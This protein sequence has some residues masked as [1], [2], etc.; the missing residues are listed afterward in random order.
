MTEFCKNCNTPVDNK[1]CPACGQKTSVSRFTMK[2][3]FHDFVH[4]FFHVDHGLFYT[5]K[6]LAQNP[7]KMLRDYLRGHRIKYFNPF[8]FILLVGGLSAF[9]LP[10]VHWHSYFIDI[11]IIVKKSVDQD[12]WNSSLKHFSIR[13]LLGIPLYALVTKIFYYRK[14]Y[15]FSEHLIANTFIRAELSF[16]MLVIAPFELFWNSV[17]SFVIIKTALMIGMMLYVAWAYAGL[18]DERITLISLAKGFIVIFI[19]IVAEMTILNL[20]IL[21]E[22]PF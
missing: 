20:V 12:L 4:G 21:K 10:K 18:F 15:N 2:H 9:L 17:D 22:L 16:G 11:G 5:A 19:A 8:T 3:L 1:F 6:K 7:G 14:N 13:L